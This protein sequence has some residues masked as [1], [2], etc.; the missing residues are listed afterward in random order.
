MVIKHMLKLI[1]PLGAAL[2]LALGVPAR[3]LADENDPPTRAA[4]LAYAEGSVS[5]EPA[6]TEDWVVA[7]LN[8]PL[9]TGDRLWSAGDGRVEMQSTARCCGCR[10]T[11][12]WHF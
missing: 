9:T 12:P 8:R 10:I 6:G 1:G 5:F 11:R 4:R 2:V 7:V 3:A